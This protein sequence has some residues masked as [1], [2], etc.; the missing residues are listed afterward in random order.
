MESKFYQACYTRVGNGIGWKAVNVS[1]D[2]NSQLL[3]EFVNIQAGNE[4]KNKIPRDHNGNALWM[5]EIACVNNSLSIT[6]VKYGLVGEHGRANFFSHGFLFN[7]A[8]EMLK[9]PNSILTIS[10]NNFKTSIEETEIVP[11]S[12]S[13]VEKI[14]VESAISE[15]KMNREKYITFIQCIYA[16]LATNTKTTIYVQA[17]GKD[18]TVKNLLYLV[19]SAIPYSLRTKVT[20]STCPDISGQDKM[21]V[22]CQEVPKHE[23]YVNPVTGE[24]N[25]LS[26]ALVNRWNR[27]PFISYFCEH[28][29]VVIENEKYFQGMEAFLKE[30]G[31]GYLNSMESLQLAFRMCKSKNDKGGMHAKDSIPD[32]LYDLLALPINSTEKYEDMV[33]DLLGIVVDSQIRLSTETE[34]LLA[35]RIKVAET[36][37]LQDVYFKYTTFVLTTINKSEAYAYL[38]KAGEDNHQFARL[39]KELKRTEKGYRLLCDFYLTELEQLVNKHSVENKELLELYFR[40]KDLS[41]IIE[42]VQDSLSD[43]A[44]EIAED[45]IDKGY[46]FIKISDEYIDL[47]TNLGLIAEIP[48]SLVE[49]YDYKCLNHFK[50]SKL[51][52]YKAFYKKYPDC[53]LGY[54]L[55]EIFNAIEEEEYD[56]VCEFISENRQLSHKIVNAIFEYAIEQGAA[57]QCTSIDF[58]QSIAKVKNVSCFELM[59]KYKAKLLCSPKKLE[60]SIEN[61]SFWDDKCVFE[62]AYSICAEYVENDVEYKKFLQKSM[63]ILKSKI[64]ENEREEKKRKAELKRSEKERKHYERVQRYSEKRSSKIEEISEGKKAERND[65]ELELYNNDENE[66]LIFIS[67]DEEAEETELKKERKK[68]SSKF[69]NPLGKFW[70]EKK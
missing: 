3:A 28:Y 69:T 47:I 12:L 10:D 7:D 22:F 1:S 57:Q 23:K 18:E 52:D 54:R 41:D 61:D 63:E 33:T 59:A 70:R 42:S 31:N 26:V 53:K 39:R 13:Y 36:L 60:N 46:G 11:E 49:K 64:K 34:Q 35:G 15:C 14:S 43:K 45:K 21:L 16:A 27:N 20:A 17:D 38:H 66:D 67:L 32:L 65:I 58:W 40:C 19:Y 51:N 48:D 50:I 9:D 25:I 55:M 6:R 62:E 5:L 2:I 30:V 4:V 37:A 56:G 29:D 8:Y 24:N 44:F 68:S